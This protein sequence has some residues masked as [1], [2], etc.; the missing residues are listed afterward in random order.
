MTLQC[1]SFLSM[2]RRVSVIEG[3]ENKCS[4][5]NMLCS[6]LQDP[7]AQPY[8]MNLQCC[9][10]IIMA[11]AACSNLQNPNAG[12]FS[13]EQCRLCLSMVF[14]CRNL[15]DPNAPVSQL[16]S[17]AHFSAW[18]LLAGTCKTQMHQSPPRAP[19]SSCC[20]VWWRSCLHA[21]GIEPLPTPTGCSWAGFWMSLSA[22]SAS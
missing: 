11:P 8:T 15:Q 19:A 7:D 13:T 22:S 9:S 2:Q 10:F 14:A 18:C 12:P 21:M 3:K 20:T 4:V 16:N 6:Y 5:W 1:R 17:D